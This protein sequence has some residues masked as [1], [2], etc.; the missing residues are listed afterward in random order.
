[1]AT[2]TVRHTILEVPWISTIGLTVSLGCIAALA[3][4]CRCAVAHIAFGPELAIAWLML[5]ALPVVHELGHVLAGWALGCRCVGARTGFAP[6]VDL[7]ARD[8]HR[9]TPGEQIVISLG[10]PLL[11]LAASVVCGVIDA[12]PGSLG[13]ASPGV[14]G[15]VL[16]GLV[17]LAN[18][19]PLPGSDGRKI[20]T[21]WRGVTTVPRA[22]ELMSRFEA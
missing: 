18:L 5:L 8:G 14:V 20:F 6:C 16:F 19:L 17:N 22:R 9:R 15:G 13:W 11:G 21:T 10:G 2:Y 1:M 4:V 7:E 12:H 3:A